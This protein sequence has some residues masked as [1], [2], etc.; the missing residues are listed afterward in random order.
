MLKKRKRDME[1]RLKTD[2]DK[3]E[4]EVM[5]KD[6]IKEEEIEKK[7]RDLLKNQ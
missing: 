6:P 3:F 4:Q 5:S 2:K 7:K 1:A